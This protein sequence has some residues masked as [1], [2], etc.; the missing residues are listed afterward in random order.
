MKASE[1]ICR[2]LYLPHRAKIANSKPASECTLVTHSTDRIDRLEGCRGS[3]GGFL[4]SWWV[5]VFKVFLSLPSV[6][7]FAIVSGP[8]TVF[9][10]LLALMSIYAF[11]TLRFTRVHSIWTVFFMSFVY[12]GYKLSSW[13]ISNGGLKLKTYSMFRTNILLA[14]E[15]WPLQSLVKNIVCLWCWGVMFAP[16]L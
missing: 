1:H 4:F 6:W 13:K 2:A 9:S 10:F 16:L 8:L 14:L 7:M 15:Q 5:L 11:E 12:W 3:S